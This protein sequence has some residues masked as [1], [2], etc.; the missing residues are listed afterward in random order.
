MD[1]TPVF[2]FGGSGSEARSFEKEIIGGSESM[3]NVCEKNAF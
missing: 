1:C 2:S 3:T